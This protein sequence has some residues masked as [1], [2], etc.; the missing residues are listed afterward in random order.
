VAPRI[1]LGH[2][3]FS[4]C[5][6]TSSFS[7]LGTFPRVAVLEKAENSLVNQSGKSHRLPTIDGLLVSLHS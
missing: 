1:L 7:I 3:S 5:S 4:E 6:S 2:Y